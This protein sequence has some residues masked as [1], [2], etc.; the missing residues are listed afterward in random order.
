MNK[1]KTIGKCTYCKDP[2]YTWQE[3]SMVDGKL[4]HS[5]CKR[6]KDEEV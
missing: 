2:V 4:Y 6:I 3:T 5:G 1:L